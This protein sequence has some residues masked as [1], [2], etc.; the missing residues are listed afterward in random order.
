MRSMLS[1]RLWLTVLSLIVASCADVVEQADEGA[2]EGPG[3]VLSALSGGA[4]S[5]AIAGLPAT[6]EAGK[7]GT[8]TV[9]ALD[10]S[11]AVATAYTGTVQL[12]ANY[13][14]TKL[15]PNYTFTAADR[16]VHTFQFTPT[17]AGR[18][19]VYATDAS[20]AASTAYATSDCVGGA[21]AYYTIENMTSGSLT[22]GVPA[23]FDVHAYDRYWNE[24]TTHQGSAVVS[25]S[26][27]GAVLPA[28]P[29]L[30]NGVATGV[31]ITFK[32]TGARSVTV[33]DV[34]NAAMNDTAWKTVVAGSGT[35]TAPQTPTITA[36]TPV[37]TAA[38]GRTAQVTARTGMKYLWTISG[39]T[40]TS[41]GGTAGVTSGS[42]NKITYT[43][44]APGTITLTA[45]EL[46][47]S[48]TASAP[49]TALVTVTAGAVKAP[50]ITATT[51]VTTGVANLT[52]SVVAR[53]GMTYTWTISGGTIT[54]E[55]GASGVTSGTVNAITYTAG[56][57]GTLRL[58]CAENNGAQT[59][60]AASKNVTVVAAPVPPNTTP[61]TPTIAIASTLTAGSATTASVTARTGLSYVW[62][63]S[64]G[65]IT[66]A[67]GTAGVTS[68][69]RNTITFVPSAAGTLT[70]GCVESNGSATSAPASASANVLAAPATPAIT[71]PAT[72]AAGQGGI[73]AKVGAR[74]GMSYVWTLSGGTITSPGA[75]AGVT[76]NGENAITLTAGSGSSL[77][78]GCIEVNAAGAVSAPAAATVA[79][80]GGSA[81][82]GHFYVVAHQ[83]DD[84]LFMNPDI[85]RSI[86]EGRPV[87]VVFV[88]AAGSPDRV[89][90]QTR[91][92]G[93]YTP[94]MSMA[95]ASFSR[96]ADAAS[97]YTCG[98]QAFA[99]KNVQ[100]CSL[101]QNPLVSLVF[102]RLPDGGLAS[103]WATDN[104]APFY[105][106]PVASLKSA[107]S[108]N[109]YT[110]AELIGTLS[111][112]LSGFSPARIGTLDST[113]AYGDDHADHITSALLTLEASHASASSAEL[114]I[115]RGYSI[116]GDGYYDIPAAEIM[117]LSTAE[118][119]EKRRI[120]VDYGGDFENGSTFD[121]W[122]KRQY[123]VSRVTGTGP[124]VEKNGGCLD[125]QG[126]A[127]TDG[128]AVIV[129]TCS[130]SAAQRWTVTADRQITGPLGKCLTVATNNALQLS[131]CTGSV[132][133]RF[134]LFA[135][136][137]LRAR[138]ATCVTDAGSGVLRASVCDPDRSGNRYLPLASQT[139]VQQAGAASA[140]STGSTFSDADVGT[141]GASTRTL[142]IANVDAD[143][144]ADA[145]VRLDSGLTCA[146]NG[147]TALGAYAIVAP[148]FSDEDGFAA[149]AY[150]ST[151]QLAD[152]SGDGRLDACGRSAT[153]ITCALRGDGAFAEPAVFTREFADD[154]AFVQPSSYR[155]LRFG[156]VNGDGYA[157]VCGRTSAGI[158]C[159][160][161]TRSG[162]F[163][164]S[165]RWLASAFT[166]A[167]GFAAD[168]YAS[169]IQLADVS[170]DGRADVCGRGPSGITCALSN[171][172]SAFVNDHPWS[173]RDDFSDAQGYA[174]AASYYGS[175]R[176]GDLNGDGAADVCGRTVKGM[177]CAL[178][179]G[180]SFEQAMALQPNAFSDALGFKA[181]AYGSSLRLGD[182]NH[183]GRADLCGRAASGLVCSFAP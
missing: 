9:R 144:W 107:D 172:A 110:K 120:M 63:L 32:S 49:A 117:N 45:V 1:L 20:S 97:Y 96:D 61:V 81:P 36:A 160:L 99:G 170:G 17:Q 119:Q 68:G 86:Q 147:H 106:K 98:A 175:V 145:C 84:L 151:V 135:N 132:A 89:S 70:V 59:S 14:D 124:L 109:T 180:L 57:A 85:A 105:E 50:T 137:Q 65:T 58:T 104:G 71:A 69:G 143:G 139:F 127:T 122:C 169:T 60:T 7:T 123:T 82:R 165:T 42:V 74:A 126:G 88:T 62:T 115:Y 95:K 77:A 16:G 156:D 24:A 8:F 93:V 182:V 56:A 30:V 79:I 146:L 125:V 112:L 157:D 53:S 118:Y 5:L 177:V 48:G 23:K 64:G 80:T 181:D 111:A 55:G 140:W 94:Y 179:N 51:P 35:V 108:A 155:T 3:S 102:L 75:A 76:S 25:S 43:A 154:G 121:N 101:T 83:D 166:D 22:V 91:E 153:G 18:Q 116:E 87:R 54:S 66:S 136:G 133:Q 158:V 152:V 167:A 174:A 38:T 40:I 130:G 28:N 78:L 19:I 39:G 163:A 15:S 173:F 52:A 26:D 162:S 47:A 168:A 11:G 31:S 41:N 114:R 100:V 90:W 21:A 176:F 129:T 92:H 2:T 159:A 178:S 27:P 33:T 72:V 134:T 4:T 113:F 161:N 37:T 128:T 67:G 150:G 103:L 171:G 138:N 141:S 142:T 148:G 13:P 10:A 12:S 164:P 34:V 131:T 6:I 73:V 44:G 183:D 29:Q 46:N 149:E